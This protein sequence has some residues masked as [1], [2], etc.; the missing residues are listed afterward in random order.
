M[1]EFDMVDPFLTSIAVPEATEQVPL[2]IGS[3][4]HQQR[5]EYVSCTIRTKVCRRD[6]EAIEA[7]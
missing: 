1:L 4:A 6:R 5:R 2:D 3:F 7:N